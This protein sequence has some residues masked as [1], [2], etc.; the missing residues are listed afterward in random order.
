M[1]RIASCAGVVAVPTPQPLLAQLRQRVHR[2]AREHHVLPQRRHAEQR[3]AGRLRLLL[4]RR[5]QLLRDVDRL[6]ARLEQPG[7]GDGAQGRRHAVAHHARRCQP[8]ELPLLDALVDLGLVAGDAAEI[9]LD[10]HRAVGAG[11]DVLNDR[12][13]LAR[14][15]RAVGRERRQLDGPLLDRARRRGRQRQQQRR[16]GRAPHLAACSDIDR[17]TVSPRVSFTFF[18]NDFSPDGARS[19]MT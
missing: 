9:E 4:H 11:V 12:L 16:R 1:A 18:G 2:R 8:V 13:E 15:Q 17:R 7:N 10:P 6:F 3:E 19:S 5:P 14:P